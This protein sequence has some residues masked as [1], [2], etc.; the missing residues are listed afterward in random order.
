MPFSGGKL[1]IVGMI[2]AYNCAQLLAH[3]YRRIPKEYF[4]TQHEI[5]HH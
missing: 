3:S 4:N 2:A 1:K 5:K